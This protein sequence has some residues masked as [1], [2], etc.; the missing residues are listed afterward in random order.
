MTA[1][2]RAQILS[3][4]AEEFAIGG[5][6]GTSTETIARRAARGRESRP[7]QLDPAKSTRLEHP[8]P[9]EMHPSI[10]RRIDDYMAGGEP[11]LR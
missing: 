2:R 8:A 7:P 5:L 6:H 1:E 9:R 4:A 3:I 10:R 11:R